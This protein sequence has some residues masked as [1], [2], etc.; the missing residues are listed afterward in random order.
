MQKATENY[1]DA[2]EYSPMLKNDYGRYLL[3]ILEEKDHTS[4]K[5][6]ILEN[7]EY[8]QNRNRRRTHYRATPL[9]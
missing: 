1:A 3:S 2:P 6:R 9:P 8:K 4:K 5:I 7:N